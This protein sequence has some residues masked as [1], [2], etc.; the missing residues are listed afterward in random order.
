LG[1]GVWH[2]IENLLFIKKKSPRKEKLLLHYL[3]DTNALFNYFKIR[4][5][6]LISIE[7]KV[8]YY[9]AVDAR[10]GSLKTLELNALRNVV[11]NVR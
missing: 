2:S 7:A 1:G 10:I 6:A 9:A 4:F 11:L 5:L 8:F 3:L